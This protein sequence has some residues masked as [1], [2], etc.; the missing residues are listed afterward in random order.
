MN[1]SVPIPA[2]AST[3]LEAGPPF[4]AGA[5]PCAFLGRDEIAGVA[6]AL[7]GDVELY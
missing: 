3:E 4:G 7:P 2:F 5:H 6:R 1:F